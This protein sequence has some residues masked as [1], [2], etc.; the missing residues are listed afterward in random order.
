MPIILGLG[1]NIEAQRRLNSALEQLRS[2][3][4]QLRES[5]WVES[6]ALRGGANYLNLVVAAQTDL[7][8]PNLL[9]RLQQIEQQQ[10]RT[11]GDEDVACALDIDL[12]C[13]NRINGTC[14]GVELPR[15]DILEH[16][17]VLCPLAQLCPEETHPE[18]GTAYKELW[19]QRKDILLRTQTLWPLNLQRSTKMR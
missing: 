2:S 13:Y 1:S 8:L 17:H 5:I 4:F 10:G 6:R 16:A 14:A 19:Q 3:L 12:L 7:D 11:R 9:S 18:L 15:K